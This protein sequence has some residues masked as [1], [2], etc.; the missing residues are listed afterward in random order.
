MFVFP[1]LVPDA[2]IEL[3]RVEVLKQGETADMPAQANHRSGSCRELRQY[4]VC[5]GAEQDNDR[6]TCQS[7]PILGRVFELG[8]CS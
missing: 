5:T 4:S 1:F 3:E 8:I 6:P 7:I 2:D